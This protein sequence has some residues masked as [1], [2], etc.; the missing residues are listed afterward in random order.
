MKG[1]FKNLAHNTNVP[2][3]G[4]YRNSTS[5]PRTG[6]NFHSRFK[7]ICSGNIGPPANDRFRQESKGTK[8]IPGPGQYTPRTE[9]ANTGQYFLSKFKSSGTAVLAGSKRGTIK[10]NSNGPGPGSYILPSDFG[11]PD[12]WYARIDRKRKKGVRSTTQL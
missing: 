2:G 8:G 7:S 6:R 9:F 1:R 4:A 3:P 10:L 12:S 5:M 11:Y